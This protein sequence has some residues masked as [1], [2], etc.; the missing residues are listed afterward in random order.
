MGLGGGATVEL[1]EE[2]VAPLSACSPATATVKRG[3][4]GVGLLALFTNGETEA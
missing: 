1:G 2:G 4:V 3:G